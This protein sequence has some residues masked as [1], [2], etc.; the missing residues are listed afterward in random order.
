MRDVRVW[1]GWLVGGRLCVEG[2]RAR[3]YVKSVCGCLGE[4][5]SL[6]CGVQVVWEVD[7]EVVG[8]G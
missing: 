6:R 8:Q 1:V 2:E 7:K 5:M 3:A 4:A